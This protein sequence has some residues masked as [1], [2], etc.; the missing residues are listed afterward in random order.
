MTLDNKDRLTELMTT[1]KQAQAVFNA[2]DNEYIQQP[3]KTA[4]LTIDTHF[5]S[6]QA[7]ASVL[8]DLIHR[9][10]EQAAELDGET[11]KETIKAV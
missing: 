2:F 11:D 8:C 1:I 4:L 9:A 6:Y 3:K 7:L 10:S 5:E